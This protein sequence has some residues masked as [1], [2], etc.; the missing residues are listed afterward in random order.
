ME[1]AGGVTRKEEY[2]L[3]ENVV[4][5]RWQCSGIGHGNEEKCSSFD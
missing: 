5:V 4:S 1:E 2:R 3:L